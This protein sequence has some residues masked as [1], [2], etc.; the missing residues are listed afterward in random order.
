MTLPL[1]YAIFPLLLILALHL[2]KHA[3]PLRGAPQ[4]MI[5]PLSIRRGLLVWMIDLHRLI[6]GPGAALD[7]DAVMR[8]AAAWEITAPIGEALGLTAT[9]LGT[10]LPPPARE[11]AS[12]AIDGRSGLDRAVARL[13]CG[14]GPISRRFHILCGR[15]SRSPALLGLERMGEAGRFLF[16]PASWARRHAP[17]A[18]SP[19]LL[20][21]LLQAA[22]SAGRIGRFLWDLAVHAG[23]RL[24][25][26]REAAEGVTAA[27]PSNT[28]AEG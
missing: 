28:P 2:A 10:N 13:A 27:A 24:A 20:R 11:A 25:P 22:R 19:L 26:A 16:P 3:A 5:V 12:D 9:V 14:S 18:G 21:R 8:R 4:A 1:E 15:V 17:A 23:A 6:E 7:W